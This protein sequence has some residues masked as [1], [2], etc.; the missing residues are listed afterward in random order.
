MALYFDT[1]LQPPLSAGNRVYIDIDWHKLYPVLA[2][3]LFDD[4]KGG[5][6]CIHDAE[7][8][9]NNYCNCHPY[10]VLRSDIDGFCACKI[11]TRNGGY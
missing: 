7:V 5:L 1:K 8:K 10:I 4:K 9:R 3:A 2:V 11:D 6:V